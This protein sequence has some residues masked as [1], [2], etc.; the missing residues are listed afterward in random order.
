MVNSKLIQS[1]KNLK[2]HL[3]CD[4]EILFLNVYPKNARML[5]QKST[6]LLI[7]TL[8]TKPIFG[9]STGIKDT[10]MNKEV[11]VYKEIVVVSMYIYFTHACKYLDTHILIYAN[12]LFLILKKKIKS[13]LLQ[14]HR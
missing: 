8:L 7:A 11:T 12:I 9:K 14:E 2:L 6:P 13:C 4:P 1:L 5:I 10:E 3:S